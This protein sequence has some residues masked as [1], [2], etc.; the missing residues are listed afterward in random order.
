M[1][2][3]IT[4]SAKF[5]K[6]AGSLSM[7]GDEVGLT[8]NHCNWKL[9]NV[10]KLKGGQGRTYSRERDVLHGILLAAPLQYL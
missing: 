7:H 9:T 2:Q 3:T 6:T 1:T 4:R 8:A 5:R 10:D